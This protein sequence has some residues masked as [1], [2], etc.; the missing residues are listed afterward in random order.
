MYSRTV[1][2]TIIQS[3]HKHISRHS[4][5][6]CPYLKEFKINIHHMPT[7]NIQ[8]IYMLITKMNPSSF[9]DK[10]CRFLKMNIWR[11]YDLIE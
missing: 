4:I 11:N 7:D 1:K 2:I 6:N 8:R 5:K 10:T 9:N 3:S